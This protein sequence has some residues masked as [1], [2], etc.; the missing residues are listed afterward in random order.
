MD[1]HRSFLDFLLLKLVTVIPV[2]RLNPFMVCSHNPF[3][4]ANPKSKIIGP[5]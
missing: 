2:E 3:L 1:P 4:K 5:L